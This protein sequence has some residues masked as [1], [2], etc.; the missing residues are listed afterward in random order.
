M[1]LRSQPWQAPLYPIHHLHVLRSQAAHSLTRPPDLH[2]ANLFHLLLK[3]L[4]VVRSP[5]ILHRALRL[6]TRLDAIV[7]VLEH[8]LER[9]LEALAP[10]NGATAGGRRACS[11]HVVHAVLADQ[12]VQ[13]LRSFL[14]GLV[15]GFGGG[16]AALA[17]NFVLREE[18]AVDAA[19][20]AAALAV[21]V[22][23]DFLLEGGLVHVARADG[24]AERDSLF[25]GFARHVLE[26][27]DGAVDAAALAEEGTNGA[28]GSFG[29]DEDDVDVGG[30][31]DL[32]LVLEDGGEA[33]GEV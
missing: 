22:G 3:R 1:Q 17:Q 14:D 19:H 7:Q 15:E 33:V 6:L 25:F 27:G 12:R 24:D 16:V 10:V 8:R 29:C 28:A 20:E 21:Q 32:G 9:L 26:D 30:D 31:F 4:P 5:G 23:V 13:G 2:P 11:V 18:H